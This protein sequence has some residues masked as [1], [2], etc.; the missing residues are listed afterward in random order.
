MTSTSKLVVNRL[1][2]EITILVP[3][4]TIKSKNAQCYLNKLMGKYRKMHITHTLNNTGTI[5]K[6]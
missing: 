6:N 1:F 5:Q 3:E 2:S 4:F